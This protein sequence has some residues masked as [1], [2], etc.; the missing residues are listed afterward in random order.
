MITRP[1]L[2]IKNRIPRKLKWGI[3]GCGRFMEE[4]FLPTLQSLKRSRL[5]SVYSGNEERGKFIASKFGAQF[6]FS[7]FDE[8]LK[9]DFEV[10]YIASTNSD[11]YWQIL[12]AAE[13]GKHIL[14]EK[15]VAIDSRQAEEIMKVCEKNNCMLM[16][17]YTYRFHPLMQKAKELIDKQ[18]IGK[19]VSISASFNIDFHPGDN[20]RFKKELSGGGA[21]RDLGTHLIDLFRF[22]N[23]EFSEVKGYIDNVVYKSDVEDFSSAM[24]KFENSGYAYLNVSFNAR[25]PFNRIEIIGHD[26]SIGIEDFIGKKNVPSKL[27]INLHD[28]KRKSFRFK[29]SKQIFVLKSVQKTILK[30]AKPAVNAYD[31]YINMEIMEAI[32]KDSLN[33]GT[34]IL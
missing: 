7:N 11:H 26:G 28:E 34:K 2:N 13:A 3:A 22:F 33:S 17:N 4:T 30:K 9:S 31:A 27:I 29:S 25:N 10:L 19:I 18:M 8:F 16:I 14:C 23:G 6:H 1:R 32:E 21:L 5:V 12:K 24:L 20:F 15:P